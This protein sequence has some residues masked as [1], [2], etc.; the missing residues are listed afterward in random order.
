MNET[1]YLRCGDP[2][3]VPQNSRG[4]KHASE[5]G[6]GAEAKDEVA[7]PKAASALDDESVDEIKL[8]EPLPRLGHFHLL[9]ITVVAFGIQV[10]QQYRLILSNARGFIVC[11]IK[12]L[13]ELLLLLIRLNG[14]SRQLC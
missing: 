3:W 13:N 7:P 5:I 12:S 9:A 2:L 4:R 11:P 6:I 10:I 14:R 1:D 8:E